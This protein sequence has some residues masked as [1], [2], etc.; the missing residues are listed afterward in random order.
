MAIMPSK[1]E[2]L[3]IFRIRKWDCCLFCR[4]E[5]LPRIFASFSIFLIS[6][7]GSLKAV[8]I[9]DG[10]LLFLALTVQF[11]GAILVEYK[12]VRARPLCLIPAIAKL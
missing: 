6:S 1:I 4:K 11:F 5:Q 9:K 10:T 12:Y 7:T 8:P 2:N 3:N